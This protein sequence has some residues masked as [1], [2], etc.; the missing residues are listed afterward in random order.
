MH[1]VSKFNLWFIFII[2]AVVYFVG[3]IVPVIMDVDAAQY[4]SISR[5]ML[6]NGSYLIVKH[7]HMDYLDKPPLLFWLS[8]FSMKL[9]GIN[10]FAY[11]LPTF[12][13]TVLGA[14]SA[15]RLGRLMYNQNVGVIA[16]I[17][18]VTNQAFFLTNHDVRTDTILANFM[19]FASWHLYAY[20]RDNK[21]IN[22]FGAFTGVGL[23]MLSKGPIGMV[24]LVLAFGPHWLYKR[25]WKSIFKWQWL[26]GLVIVGV[27]LAP[28]TYGLYL[29]FGEE[30]VRFY[31]WTQSFGRI[32]G[33][34]EWKNDS[35]PFFF[36]HT[37]LWSFIPWMVIASYAFLKKVA[38]L[39]TGRLKPDAEIIT[40]SGFLLVMIAMSMS[41]YKLPHYIYVAWIFIVILTAEEIDNT[42]QNITKKYKW[43][44]GF[45]IF[46]CFCLW[47]VGIWFIGFVFPLNNVLVWL[48]MVAA[49][50]GAVFFLARDNT[51]FGKLIMPSLITI[52]GINFL[53]NAHLYP[54]LGEY[55]SGSKGAFYIQENNIPL[56][57]MYQFGEHQMSFEFYNQKIIKKTDIDTIKS[58][59]AN[60]T[61]WLFAH[62]NEKKILDKEKI[63]YNVV[64]KFKDFHITTL[65]IKFLRPSTRDK[66]LKYYYLIEVPKQENLGL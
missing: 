32:T 10:Q 59:M 8:S 5:E 54:S 3:M 51:P 30:G 48:G 31:Y 18:W 14:Y 25:D 45:Q 57:N 4:A 42:L 37:F 36:W 11:R 39:V 43:Y 38:H 46:I 47:L 19:A 44:L 58:N 35:D 27:I 63:K 7:R 9:F 16:S 49:L 24:A 1:V 2:T 61:V 29:Q 26:V 13:T 65:H 15:F 40:L 21:A 66:Y 60:G 33:E 6:E 23:A 64:E 20:S 41:H 28:M 17:L 50:G 56:N 34:N 52:V 22:F 53:L 12:L 55:Q 62:E